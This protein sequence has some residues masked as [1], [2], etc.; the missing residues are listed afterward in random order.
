MSG[1][2]GSVLLWDCGRGGGLS[3][4]PRARRRADSSGAEGVIGYFEPSFVVVAAMHLGPWKRGASRRVD[5]RL[6]PRKH[7][8][9]AHRA[10]WDLQFQGPVGD[11]IVVSYLVLLLNAQNLVEIDA[12]NR[13]DG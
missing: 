5:M 1:S 3:T 8:T 13:D 7:E 4:S 11:A 10:L 6:D 9:W 2:S 12:R